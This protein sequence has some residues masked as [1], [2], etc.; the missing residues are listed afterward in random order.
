M[1][2]SALKLQGRALE[3][4]FCAIA[5]QL[6]GDVSS[7]R[8]GD[9]LIRCSPI[10]RHGA[11][12]PWSMAPKIFSSQ[13]WTRLGHAAE[14]MYEIMVATMEHFRSCPSFR[15][16]FCLPA[17]L[18]RLACHTPQGTQSLPLARV[19]IFLN[20]ESGAFSFCETNTDGTAGFAANDYVTQAIARSQTYRLFKENHPTARPVYVSEAWVDACLAHYE[21]WT[22]EQGRHCSKSAPAI[23]LVD[24][25]ESIEVGE[26]QSFIEL[27][28]ARGFSAHFSDVRGL[29][30]VGDGG[31]Q[32]LCDSEGAVDIVWKRAVTGE[33]FQKEN[34]GTEALTRAIEEDLACVLGG[35]D[36]WPVATKTFFALLHRPE[37]AEYLTPEQLE[38]VK[39]HV[40]ETY[41]L[42]REPELARFEENREEWIVKPAGGYNAVGV[43]AGADASA[44]EW[45]AALQ[46][47]RRDGGV[48][49]R[50]M[51]QYATPIIPGHVDEA[52][53][54]L[55]FPAYNNMLGLFLFDGRFAGVFSRCG[56]SHVIGEFQGRLEQGCIVVE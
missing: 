55:D 17:E 14:T 46:Q 32:V 37:A 39:E 42:G 41:L 6:G 48:I 29:R 34:P 12:E 13:E 36:S 24:F 54:A 40:P 45:R 28:K 3:D 23:A 8:E 44:E 51:P 35:F 31:N 1:S 11:S 50:Y 7:R 33:L 22:A 53:D 4:E 20:E 15:R 38:F 52:A 18:E 19:D 9:L 25:A 26:A 47:M 56:K 27:F 43:L 5:S 30:V 16:L 49:Q 10:A 21:R 2:H